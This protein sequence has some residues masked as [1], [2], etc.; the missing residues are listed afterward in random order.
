MQKVKT[1]NEVLLDLLETIES[2]G[3]RPLNN[4]KETLERVSLKDLQ[5]RSSYK[6]KMNDILF[7][8][9]KLERGEE[10]EPIVVNKDNMIVDGMKRYYAYM[11][12]NYKFLQVTRSKVY[13]EEFIG[14][15][16]SIKKN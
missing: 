15:G 16:F 4:D 12:H 10:L 11:R 7:F 8:Y 5:V 9:E 13:I 2:D 14:E 1:Y 6:G 3:L